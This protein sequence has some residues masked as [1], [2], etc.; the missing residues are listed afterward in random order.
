M[1]CTMDLMS[2]EETQWD[3]DN[4]GCTTKYYKK[5]PIPWRADKVN[6]FFERL[7]EKSTRASS[8]RS[9]DM[10]VPRSVGSPAD[11]LKPLY[12]TES[13]WMFK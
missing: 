10:T 2:S 11:R 6:T 7:D 9:K 12:H 13:A 3:E 5:K 1:A 4:D 8:L